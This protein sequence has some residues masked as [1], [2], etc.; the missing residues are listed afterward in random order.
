[1][2]KRTLLFCTSYSA[3]P[4]VWTARYQRWL[5]SVQG[6]GLHFDRAILVDDASPALPQWFDVPVYHVD[7]IPEAPARVSIHRFDERLGQK[8]EGLAFPGWYR[9]FAHAV[10]YGVAAGFEKLIHIESDAYLLSRRAIEFFN[11]ADSGWV[12]LWCR[13]YRWPESTFQIINS[14]QFPQCLSFFDRPYAEHANSAAQPI[15]NALPYTIVNRD[16]IGD[17]YGE[18]STSVPFN[19]DFVSQV[20]WDQGDRYFW[21]MNG[22]DKAAY[23]AETK[24]MPKRTD[25]ETEYRVSDPN[26]YH[27]GVDYRQFL[28]FLDQNIFPEG[29]LEVGTHQGDSVAQFSCDSICIDPHFVLGSEA[30][31]QKQ[32]IF[33]FQTTSDRFFAECNPNRYVKH[34][35]IG[36]LDGLHYF[37]SLLR[38][39]MNFE[40]NA[41][42]RSIAIMHDCFP[43]NT[44]M[45]GRVHQP[46]PQSEP[47]A[48]RAFWTGDVWKVIPI[49]K[50]LR[51]DL[52]IVGVN[53]PPTGLV[54][55]S[56]L[57]PESRVLDRNFEQTVSGMA[58]LTLSEFNI[59]ELWSAIPMLDGRKILE[60]PQIFCSYFRLRQ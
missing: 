1:M 54:L 18:I 6:S 43:L 4:G 22:L 10:S 12:G 39:F 23:G 35:D 13:T 33:L 52:H 15:E 59:D 51:P 55:I 58:D 14:D 48:T 56:Q 49:L 28:A 42:Y 57:D 53:A 17:R 31:R 2:E 20:R 38:D 30:L 46:G 44:R 47:E 26:L 41:H 37:E 5:Q 16:L 21:W 25:L 32:R 40:R 9:S 8:A 3:S 34:L 11:A 45:T 24:A 36:F 27:E 19:A 29:Y 7:A 50:A 60:A